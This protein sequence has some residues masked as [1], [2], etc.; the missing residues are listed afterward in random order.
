MTPVM[1][2]PVAFFVEKEIGAMGFSVCVSF[3]VYLMRTKGN[4]LITPS[5]I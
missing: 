4:R 5:R 2:D 3:I 1:E